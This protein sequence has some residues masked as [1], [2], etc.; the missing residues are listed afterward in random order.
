MKEFIKLIMEAEKPK[1]DDVPEPKKSEQSKIKPQTQTKSKPK[2]TGTFGQADLDKASQP[3]SNLPAKSQP[4]AKEGPKQ[5]TKAKTPKLKTGTAQQT[6][7]ATANIQLPQSA[8]DKLSRMTVDVGDEPEIPPQEEQFYMV[9]PETLPS[10]INSYLVDAG[11]VEPTWHQVRNLPGYMSQAIRALGRPLFRTQTRTSLEEIQCLANLMGQGPNTNREINAVL[12]WAQENCRDLGNGGIDFEGSIPGYTADIH[13]YAGEDIRFL[14]VRDEY[15]GYVYAW[16]E[17]DSVT[18]EGGE[19]D[20]AI[21]A[22]SKKLGHIAETLHYKMYKL[23]EN[24][25]TLMKTTKTIKI[26]DLMEEF[27]SFVGVTPNLALMESEQREQ[28]IM[29][30]YNMKQQTPEGEKVIGNKLINALKADRGLG[31]A[32]LLRQV[33]HEPMALI[34]KLAEADPTGPREDMLVY[35]ARM[36]VAGEIHIEDI[37]IFKETLTK[38]M[39]LRNKLENKDL[40]SYRTLRALYD[41]LEKAE[42]TK[43]AEVSTFKMEG[44]ETIISEENIKVLR[45]VTYEAGQKLADSTSWCT[46]HEGQYKH[47]T[48]SGELYVVLA[49]FSNGQ[50]RKF[51]IHFESDQAMDERNQRMSKQDIAELSKIPGWTKFLNYLIELKYAKYFDTP[52]ATP[53]TTP[54]AESVSSVSGRRRVRASRV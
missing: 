35:I 39:R 40:N 38:F 29:N 51:Q 5:K 7:N 19:A 23:L 47:Y 24:K 16:P 11:L 12:K 37:Q 36:Y 9:I 17:Q 30:Q 8:H 21:G 31:A 15:G 1:D 6:R 20:K 25:R 44:A 41:T 10:V 45:P 26:D 14:V 27:N 52:A 3:T 2:T 50:N 48:Q 4:K 46:R 34:K 33:E 22:P 13:V 49:K 32:E 53:A 18:P 54:T 43:Q 42:A 28:F